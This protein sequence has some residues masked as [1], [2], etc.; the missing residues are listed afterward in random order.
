MEFKYKSVDQVDAEI[1]KTELK[2]K[3]L[4][5]RIKLSGHREWSS[6]ANFV[7]RQL[8]LHYDVTKMTID[9][10]DIMAVGF[11]TI[12]KRAICDVY[13]DFQNQFS[14]KN[15]EKQ[16]NQG[17]QKLERLKEQRNFLISQEKRDGG[18]NGRT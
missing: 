13:R 4:D 8:K 14:P 2:I 18:N 7:K 3:D 1:K 12:E 10:K 9:H 6:V 5:D 11:R 16:I 17:Y 15:C